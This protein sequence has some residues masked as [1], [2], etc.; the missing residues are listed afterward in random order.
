[1][2][3]WGLRLIFLLF[4]LLNWIASPE[5]TCFPLSLVSQEIRPV[6]LKPQGASKSPGSLLKSYYWAPSLEFWIYQVWGGA[7]EFV[8]LTSSQVMLIR[9]VPGPH[10]KNHH[11]SERPAHQQLCSLLAWL[12]SGYMALG[13][14]QNLSWDLLSQ[15]FTWDRNYHPLKWLE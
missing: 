6:F 1:M 15:A 7:W 2:V 4:F 14:P 5:V 11:S 9:L 8:L 3:N 13:K 12:L 10:C